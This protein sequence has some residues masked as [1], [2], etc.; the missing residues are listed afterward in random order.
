MSNDR[1]RTLL[2]PRLLLC[3]AALLLALS[4]AAQAPP[5]AL[6]EA[7][8]ALR[9]GRAAEAERRYRELI[10][11]QP[12]LADAHLGLAEALAAQGRKQ[13]AAT[14]LT[15]VGEGL[16][17]AGLYGAAAGALERAAALVPGS[18]RIHA[19]L[20]RALALD[21]KPRAAVAALERAVALGSLGEADLRTRLYLGTALWDVGEVDRAEAELRRLAGESGAAFLPLFQLGRLLLWRGRAAEAVPWLQR[22]AAANPGAA[23]A[24]VELARALEATGEAAGAVAAYRR[25]AGIDP[26]R[27]DA[28]YGLA[29]LL[30]RT[31]DREGGRR[32]LEV[33]RRLTEEQRERTR[34]EG[35]EAARLDRGWFLLESGQVAEAIEQFAALGESAD[36]LAGLA[37]AYSAAG[38]HARAVATLERAVGL[39]P[40]RQDLRLRLAEQRLAA[41]ERRP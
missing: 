24:Q 12:G 31:G 38:D 15:E 1:L 17:G 8:G 35:L 36:A 40:D 39:A 23:D 14:A 34:R 32:E 19:L 25:A 2:A 4:A 37:S 3:A 20:G 7:A 16:I 11:A 10:A 5:A 9:A 41:G 6:E 22:A 29:L 26:R 30:A 18:G 13:E 27:A 33:Y 28:R 21:Q